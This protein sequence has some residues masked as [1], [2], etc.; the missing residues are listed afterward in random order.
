MHF[1]RLNT[2]VMTVDIIS[3]WSEIIKSLAEVF[4]AIAG[5]VCA[6]KGI[7]LLRNLKERKLMATFGFWSQLVIKLRMLKK[8]LEHSPALV[9]NLYSPKAHELWPNIAAPLEADEID[10]FISISNEVLLFVKAASDQIPAYVGWTDD[11]SNLI[12][13]LDDV[14]YYNIKEL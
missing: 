5:G 11:Y 3:S 9:N 2:I 13:F 4:A 14:L 8:R 7:F 10:E 12:D 1:S 6:I